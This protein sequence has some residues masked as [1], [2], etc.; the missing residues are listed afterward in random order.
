[1][2]YTYARIAE[3]TGRPPQLMTNYSYRAPDISRQRGVTALAR[4]LTSEWMEPS[5]DLA[6]P[7]QYFVIPP[8]DLAHSDASTA[9]KMPRRGNGIFGKASRPL[10]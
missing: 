1:M 10:E 7:Q 2:A 3:D 9:G 6:T 8:L 5:P 4:V